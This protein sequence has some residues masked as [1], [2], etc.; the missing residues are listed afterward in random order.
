MKSQ[1]QRFISAYGRS[2][3]SLVLCALFASTGRPTQTAFALPAPAIA[4][5]YVPRDIAEVQQLVSPIALYPDAL[6]AQVLAATT[7]PDDVMAA[8]RW[9]DQG[10]NLQAIDA[11]PWDPSVKGVA[12]YPSILHYLAGQPDW[13]NNLGDAFLNQQSDVMSAVQ[14]LRGNALAAGTLTS[15]PQ[16]TVINEDG[17]IQIIPTNPAIV[18]VPIYNPQVVYAPPPY[19]PGDPYPQYVT[20]G[21]GVDVGDWL[22]YDIDWHDRAM[23]YGHWG[24][25]R[26]W[27]HEHDRDHSD[28]H[29]YVDDRP[30][31]YRPG[32]FRDRGGHPIEAQASHWARDEHRPAPRPV[33]RPAP[34]R[35][36]ERP[37]R[38]YPQ[39]SPAPPDSRAPTPRT[40]NNVPTYGRGTDVSRQ[41]DRGRASRQNAAPQPPQPA[42]HPAP[43]PKAQPRPA[44][45]PARVEPA[46]A[47]PARV[48]PARVEPPRAQPAHPEPTR[49]TPRQSTPPPAARPS[50]PVK[51]GAMGGYQRGADASHNASRG[52]QSRGGH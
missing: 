50:A 17:Y 8:S 1:F 20:Y 21:P 16:Q 19:I 7:Y 2:S 30:G 41:S 13:M 29:R 23:Y 35:P 39:R 40:P 5:A 52:T 45:Q 42:P 24:R 18:Y 12:R 43:T 46:R 44:P 28:F 6:L 37:E 48:E 38:G 4:V 14:N 26:P 49:T 34:S 25:D 51:G 3:L 32:L 47:Q 10:N 22:G 15:T 11:Q 33:D 36:I 27:W 9:E 31:I